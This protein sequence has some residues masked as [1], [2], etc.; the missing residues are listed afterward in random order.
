MADRIAAMRKSLVSELSKAGSP[1]NWSHV[2]EQIGMFA[3]TGLTEEMCN[4]LAK[5]HHIY[6]T[7]DG[8]IS[9]A[10]LNTKNVGYV[11]QAFDK[12]T[13]NAKL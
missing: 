8:R 13:R 6:M 1:H 7:K 2:T 11:A 12:V 4:I 5:A 9:V 10:G 3:F